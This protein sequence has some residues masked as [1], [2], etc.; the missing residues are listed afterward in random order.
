MQLET[1]L[2]ALQSQQAII[3]ID[4]S[5]TDTGLTVLTQ[6][7]FSLVT[8]VTF[9]ECGSSKYRKCDLLRSKIIRAVEL[10]HS[11]GYTDVTI[12]YEQ[13]RYNNPVNSKKKTTFGNTH[14]S[15]IMEGFIWDAA[16]RCETTLYSVPT[17]SYRSA[18]VGNTKGVENDL[19]IDPSKYPTY[20]FLLSTGQIRP[21]L[22][23]PRPSKRKGIVLYKG[24]RMW[25]NDNKGDSA[26]IALYGTLPAQ[27]RKGANKIE[28]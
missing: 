16:A 7:G 19:G 13:I 23:T 11:N 18:V 1:A 14:G 22:D 17:I 6:G 24:E 4:Q 15:S 28:L 20:T 5:Y 26:C 8:S 3:G 12:N 9:K 27:R 10:C 25:Y 2:S 21:F